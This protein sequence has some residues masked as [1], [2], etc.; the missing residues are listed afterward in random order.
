M[1]KVFIVLGFTKDYFHPAPSQNLE[2][3]KTEK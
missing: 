3:R 2:N 1:V